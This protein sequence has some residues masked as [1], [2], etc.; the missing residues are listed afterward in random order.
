MPEHFADRLAEKIRETGSLLVMGLDPRPSWLPDEILG[1]SAR[2]KS[3]DELASAIRSFDRQLIEIASGRV[4]AVKVQIAFYEALGVAG[5]EAFRKTLEEA[6]EASLL[7]IADAKRADIG[8]TARAYAGAFLG[9]QQHYQEHGLYDGAAPFGA[10]ALTVNPLFGTDGLEPFLSASREHGKG[11]FVLVKTSNPGAADLQD[12]AVDDRSVFEHV[13]GT[14]D[15]MTD[16]DRGACGYASA[17]AVVGATQSGSLARVRAILPDHFLLTP[18]VGAQ[19]GNPEDL[20][21]LV[22]DEGLGVLVPMARSLIYAFRDRT[23]LDWKSAVRN[24]VDDWNER[25]NSL[26][27]PG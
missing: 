1:G 12:L 8:S 3:V 5:L 9:S 2:E 22:D 10:D 7:V 20:K 11:T 19:G 4:P 25:L 6:Q 26:I 17:G 15:T 27:L 21:T 18:G 16:D 13:A 23:D 14:L 24:R